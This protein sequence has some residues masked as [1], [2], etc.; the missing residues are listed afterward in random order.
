MVSC[1][2]TVNGQNNPRLNWDTPVAVSKFSGVGAALAEARTASIQLDCSGPGAGELKTISLGARGDVSLVNTALFASS[3]ESVDYKVV[4]SHSKKS[5]A[6]NTMNVLG[7]A[8]GV[9]Y[10][11]TGPDTRGTVDLT[12]TP[13]AARATAIAGR[14]DARVILDIYA[15]L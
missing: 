3:N 8:D 2:A 4:V 13:V 6:P 9:A 7:S 10:T 1:T 12:V 11:P 5:I 14:A 15:G